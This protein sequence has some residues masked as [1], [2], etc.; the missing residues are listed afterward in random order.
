LR[1]VSS[2]EG[3]PTSASLSHAVAVAAD[4][5]ADELEVILTDWRT[6]ADPVQLRRRLAGMLVKLH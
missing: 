5:V 3:S 2:T 1:I 4:P 6:N